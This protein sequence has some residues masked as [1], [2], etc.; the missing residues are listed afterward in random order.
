MKGILTYS[1]WAKLLTSIKNREDDKQNLSIIQNS[2][3]DATGSALQ[4]FITRFSR[5][6]ED[7]IN[8]AKERFKKNC[9]RSTSSDSALIQAL[10]SLRKEF[11]YLYEVSSAIDI[12]EEYKTQFQQKIIEIANETQTA[13]ESTQSTD[14]F[15]RL[16][17][18]VRNHKVNTIG[19]EK[20]E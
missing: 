5:M 13:L 16:A 15:G 19:T 18:L 8:D 2:K 10:L 17:A 6:L 12:P 1:E 7:R 9:S 14:I 11:F 20:H 4:R 3:F